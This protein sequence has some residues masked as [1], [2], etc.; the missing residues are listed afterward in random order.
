VA[1]APPRLALDR[2]TDAM[3]APPLAATLAAL[4]LAGCVDM[5]APVVPPAAPV[6]TGESTAVADAAGCGAMTFDLAIFTSEIDDVERIAGRATTAVT[7]DSTLV[8]LWVEGHVT[9]DAVAELE[10]REQR[11]WFSGARPYWLWRGSRQEDGT[12][13]VREP[14]PFCGREVTLAT[15]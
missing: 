14:E 13:L 9:P 5:F 8:G 15:R 6:W 7:R 11:P 4:L 1:A 2:E 3:H 10:V 12:I